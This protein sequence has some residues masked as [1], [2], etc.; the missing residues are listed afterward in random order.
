MELVVRILGGLT[1][2]ISLSRH[3]S[4]FFSAEW[5]PSS[6]LEILRAG[7]ESGATLVEFGVKLQKK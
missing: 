1:F 7:G 6:S 2:G 5:P 3:L 4:A